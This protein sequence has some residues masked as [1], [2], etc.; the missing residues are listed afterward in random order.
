M[1]HKCNYTSYNCKLYIY[2]TLFVLIINIVTERFKVG[3]NIAWTASTGENKSTLEKL[4]QSWYDEVAKFDRN[5]V[6]AYG[7]VIQII[8][9]I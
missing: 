6:S 8:L 7:W 9:I 5:L 2:E 1:T 4:I 3:Q